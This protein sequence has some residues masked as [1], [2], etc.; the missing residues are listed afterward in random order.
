MI[1]EDLAREL[2]YIELGI[3][4]RIRSQHVGVHTSRVGGDGLEFD[5]HRHYRPGDDVRRID[6]NV[7]ARI[8]APFVRQT[9]AER[10][11][12][13][14]VVVDLSR[15][16]NMASDGRSKREALIRLAASLLFSASADRISTGFLAFADRVL[17]WTPPTGNRRRAWAALAELRTL[18]PPAGLSSLLPALDHLLQVLKRPALVVI[19]SDFLVREPLAATPQFGTLAARHDVVAVILSDKL[20]ARLPVGK[21]VMRVKDLESGVER[22][23]RLDDGVRAR[24]AAAVGQRRDEL[25]R[26]CYRT[27]IEPVFVDAGDDVVGQLAGVFARRR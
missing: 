12:D 16:M 9:V 27:G 20:E 10:E 2:Q 13:L 6:W 21:G 15:S 4:R 19:V 14:V 7:T 17:R 8:G 11:L 23:I 5:Q 24:Y 18:E 1:P 3:A 25:T 22:V 26:G